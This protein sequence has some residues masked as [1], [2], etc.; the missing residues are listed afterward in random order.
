MPKVTHTSNKKSS[1]K[2]AP[3]P[4]SSS[5]INKRIR[6]YKRMLSKRKDLNPNAKIQSERKLIQLQYLYGEKKIDEREKELS[7]KY[8]KI[9][10]FESQKVS[11]KL[12]KHKKMLEGETDENA[13]KKI[14]AKIEDLK[15]KQNYILYYPR[16]LP[17]VS[18]FPSTDT[19]ESRGSNSVMNEVM[20]KVK[21][22]M[23]NGQN[24]DELKKEYRQSYRQRLIKDGVIEDAKPIIA[25]D[26]NKDKED[27]KNEEMDEEKDDFFE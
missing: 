12:R 13:K 17:Y 14:E 20:D 19:D 18:L 21:K 24:F 11:R 23:E 26:D 16:T 7:K 10:H 4:E 1:N 9:K 27:E 6:S 15:V 2:N 25:D 8:H 22:V 5:K 3:L